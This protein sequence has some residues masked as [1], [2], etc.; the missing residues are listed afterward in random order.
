MDGIIEKWLS[1]A[2][3]GGRVCLKDGLK[4]QTHFEVIDNDRNNLYGEAMNVQGLLIGTPKI[5]SADQFENI[6]AYDYFVEIIPIEIRKKR[7]IPCF[8]VRENGLLNWTNDA[9]K[10]SINIFPLK[11][12]LILIFYILI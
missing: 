2:K 5:F 9:S 12:V 10:P 4:Q 7:S 3:V 6:K 11:L 8:Y 1:R